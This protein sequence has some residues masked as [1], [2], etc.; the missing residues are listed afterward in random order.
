MR[1]TKY[2]Y[3]IKIKDIDEKL[4]NE[5]YN[6]VDNNGIDCG[7]S[8]EYNK[9][10]DLFTLYIYCNHFTVRADDTDGVRIELSYDC[11]MTFTNDEFFTIELY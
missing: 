1:L 2:L 9:E 3:R 6:M 8:Y 10:C 7:M 5:Y 11:Y 4:F